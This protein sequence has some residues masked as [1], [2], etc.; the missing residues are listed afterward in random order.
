[1][2]CPETEPC[3]NHSY[4]S[5]YINFLGLSKSFFIVQSRISAVHSF[6]VTTLPIESKDVIAL[7]KYSK[8]FNNATL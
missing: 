6:E 3:F 7:L 5:D 1:M 2:I 8:V 4:P